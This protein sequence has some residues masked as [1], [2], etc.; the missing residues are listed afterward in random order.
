M[1]SERW[2]RAQT[3][4]VHLLHLAYSEDFS[5]NNQPCKP[6]LPIAIW[7]PMQLHNVMI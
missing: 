1:K 5:Q 7:E 3:V 4:G 6:E 2:M